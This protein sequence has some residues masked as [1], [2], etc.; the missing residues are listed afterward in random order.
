MSALGAKVKVTSFVFPVATIGAVPII[1]LNCKS[2]PTLVL[3][4]PLPE[5][6]L[7]PVF[8]SPPAAPGAT[9]G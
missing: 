3:K 7:L 5:P 9:A 6:T 4:S 1:L 8:A 2:E